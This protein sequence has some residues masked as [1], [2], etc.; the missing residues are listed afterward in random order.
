MRSNKCCLNRETRPSA[1]PRS[2]VSTFTKETTRRT[3]TTKECYQFQKQFFPVVGELKSE[4]EEF[5][6][7]FFLDQLDE[8]N[9][10]VCNVRN[11]RTAFWLQTPTDRFYPDFVAMLKD[12]RRLVVESKGEDRWSN[13]DSKE[14]RNI[15]ELWANASDGHCLFVMPKGSDRNAMRRKVAERSK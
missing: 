12:G 8:V 4:G 14:K 11:P 5:D 1:R 9:W 7:A 10:W 13:D 2:S 15:G 6:C 3:G